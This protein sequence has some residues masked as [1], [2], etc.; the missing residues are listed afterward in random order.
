MFKKILLSI[1]WFSIL[2]FLQT[3]F[4]WVVNITTDITTNTT[5]SSSNEYVIQNSISLISWKTLTI[6]AW[7]I[8]KINDWVAINISWKLLAIWNTSS[9]IIF[10]S[11]NDNSVWQ[12]LG[13]WTPAK[14]AWNYLYF[15]WAWANNSELNYTEIRYW[16]IY[17]SMW[18]IYIQSS[19]IKIKN[20]LISHSLYDWIR[21]SDWI[22]TIENNILYKN[23][24]YWINIDYWTSTIQY[25]LYN[26]NTSWSSNIPLIESIE[27][28][29]W[30]ID[31]IDYQLLPTSP[32]INKW[33][34]SYGNHNISNDRYDIWS[35]EYTWYLILDYKATVTWVNWR[36]LNYEWVFSESPSWSNIVFLEPYN[37]NISTDKDLT[38]KFLLIKNWNYKLNLIIKE[39]TNIL[40]SKTSNFTVNN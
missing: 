36:N 20:S 19:N 8:I 35:N 18:M 31:E 24:K 3:T 25:N 11:Y 2:F 10:T 14:W 27:A 34:P 33:N 40:K 4:A 21:I 6:Q 12:A 28:N 23:W 5:W 1:Y 26:Q 9:K 13:T 16:G 37:W 22:S 32:A 39:W 30:F 29:P 38:T 15:Y 17:D 7:T